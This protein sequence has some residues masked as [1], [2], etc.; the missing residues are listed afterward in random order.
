MG[1]LCPTTDEGNWRGW[2][3]SVCSLLLR[4][5]GV[6]GLAS[7][8][9]L[10]AVCFRSGS[11]KNEHLGYLGFMMFHKRNHSIVVN[12]K[13]KQSIGFC[14]KNNLCNGKYLISF[15]DLFIYCVRFC[16]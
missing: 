14:V 7:F 2:N 15:V 10:Y 4:G 1:F 3:G 9:A 8:G 6:G 13:F 11:R 12:R 16:K 5:D